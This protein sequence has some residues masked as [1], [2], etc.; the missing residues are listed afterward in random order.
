MSSNPEVKYIAKLLNDSDDR[1]A[2]S[3]MRHLL[4]RNDTELGQLIDALTVE[5]SPL[6][7]RR[8]GILRDAISCRDNR[9]SFYR[10]INSE[11]PDIF[12]GLTALHLL[13]FDQDSD[14]EE[15][16]T[17][18]NKLRTKAA[19][20]EINSLQDLEFFMRS[21]RFMPH[22]EST[23]FP[24]NYCIGFLLDEKYSAASMLMAV[25]ANLSVNNSI[26]LVRFQNEFALIDDQGNMLKGNN[27]WHL[28]KTPQKEDF[29]IWDNRMLLRYIASMLLACAVNSDSYRYV[30][31]IAMA[32]KGDESENVFNKFPYPFT[33]VQDDKKDSETNLF[34]G[35]KNE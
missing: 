25:G 18:I 32:L 16:L 33:I 8:V 31:T 4:S 5:K 3:V 26:Q 15:L 35:V 24:E 14:G 22:G 6:L 29:E 19:R 13:W 34:E 7:S 12:A 17:E 2:F 9:R 23:I 21:E 28:V 27:S 1:N 10:I 11:D 20:C 30:M